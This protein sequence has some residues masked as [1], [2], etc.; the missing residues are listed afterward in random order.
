MIINERTKYIGAKVQGGKIVMTSDRVTN[1]RKEMQ[2]HLVAEWG[3]SWMVL[4]GSG[5]HVYPV[6]LVISES[7]YMKPGA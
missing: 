4:R 6:E 2:Q 1:S 7:D 3:H 5:W